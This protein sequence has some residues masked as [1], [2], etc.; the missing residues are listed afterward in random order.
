MSISETEL[1]KLDELKREETESLMGN[2]GIRLPFEDW[3]HSKG[4]DLSS[5][6]FNQS[7]DANPYT[8]SD[9]RLAYDIWCSAI[10]TNN[11]Q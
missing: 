8:E 5:D 9:T 4:F 6:F 11:A 1:N 3:A 10:A 7:G 2:E